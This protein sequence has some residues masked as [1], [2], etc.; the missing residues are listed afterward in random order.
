M[1]IRSVGA[2]WIIAYRQAG[3]KTDRYDEANNPFWLLYE[4]AYK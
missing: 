4:C 3:K 1:I 2:E